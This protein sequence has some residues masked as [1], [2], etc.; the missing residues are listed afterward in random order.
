VIEK[1]K[2]I[3]L[4]MAL[5]FI[6]S[7]EKD[8]VRGA[9]DAQKIIREEGGCIQINGSL[10]IFDISNIDLGKREEGL[11]QISLGL[12]SNSKRTEYIVLDVRSSR[13]T[14]PDL[15]GLSKPIST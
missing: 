5:G 12:K 3:F 1:S 13:T 10:K 14:I 9:F 7:E 2:M 6:I 11:N 4:M 15:A 8:F